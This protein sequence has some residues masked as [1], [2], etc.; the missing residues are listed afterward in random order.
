MFYKSLILKKLPYDEFILALRARRLFDLEVKS[1]K[2]IFFHEIGRAMLRH[3]QDSSP[4]LESIRSLIR[5]FLDKHK[6][7]IIHK[8][9][10]LEAC[11]D[12]SSYAL[13]PLHPEK[14]KLE[15]SILEPS[16]TLPT[17]RTRQLQPG[18]LHR[19]TENGCDDSRYT[20]ALKEMGDSEFISPKYDLVPL[21]LDPPRW[22]ANVQYK[23]FR[24]Q[25]EANSKKAAKHCASKALWLEM[26]HEAL[27]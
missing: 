1:A 11:S 10:D 18:K 13:L 8:A 4:V 6:D 24:S 7:D 22:G 2:I 26:G 14:G 19:N 25:G 5:T 17:Q 15:H 3:N 21:S 20:I 12:G 16:M 9:H 23:A 27:T